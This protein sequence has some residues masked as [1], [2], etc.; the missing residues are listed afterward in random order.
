[1]AA[2]TLFTT[3]IS[4]LGVPHTATYS[5]LEYKSYPTKL[6]YMAFMDLLY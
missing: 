1:M 4:M 3:Y 2:P 5:N 6:A